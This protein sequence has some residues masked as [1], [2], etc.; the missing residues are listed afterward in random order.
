M[1][2]QPEAAERLWVRV[3]G[4]LEEVGSGRRYGPA[5]PDF[6]PLDGL[7]EGVW[8]NG[9][10]VGWAPPGWG[11][12]SLNRAL[13]EGARIARE[14]RAFLVRRLGHKLRSSAI[15]LQEFA[16][17][18]AFGRQELLEQIHDQALDVGRRALALETVTLDPKDAPRGVVIGALLNLA[19]AGAHRQL[20][21]DAVVRARESVLVEALTRAYEWMGGPGSTISGELA[22][23]WWRLEVAAAPDR[24]ALVIPELGE[25]LVRHLVDTLLEGWLDATSPDRAVIYLPAM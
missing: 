8:L 1:F 14:R 7:W 25:P 10:L 13:D 18:A 9:R 12:E 16:R 22:G 11:R 24:Q 6:P 3:G 2:D 15:A 17:Q 20:P 23:S 5:D 4:G 21:G 19:A